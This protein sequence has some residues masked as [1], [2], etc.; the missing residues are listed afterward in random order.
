MGKRY[1]VKAP[2]RK[3]TGPAEFRG[4]W[5]EGDTITDAQIEA[6]GWRVST[7]LATGAIVECAEKPAPKPVEVKA[8]PGKAKGRTDG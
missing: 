7:L 4:H 2:L 3:R 6:C 5:A 8:A 1:E